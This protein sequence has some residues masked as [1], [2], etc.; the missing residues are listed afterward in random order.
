[1]LAELAGMPHATIIMDS[2]VDGSG[3]RVKRELEGGWIQWIAMPQPAVLTIQSGINRLRY[4]T[5][6]GIMAAKKKD[7]RVVDAPSD[8]AV[9]LR[10]VSMY[11]PEKRKE[12]QDRDRHSRRAGR[13]LV[14]LLRED[15]RVIE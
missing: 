6:K 1:M 11:V 13:E 9:G 10:I 4:A 15:A 5:L 2:S 12:T 7:I 14:R 8:P 3:L